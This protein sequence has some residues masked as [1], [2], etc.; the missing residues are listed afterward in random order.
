[1]LS[2]SL[3]WLSMV[4]LPQ[5][6]LAEPPQDPRDR[7]VGTWNTID[8]HVA[9]GSLYQPVHGVRKRESVIFFE[10]KGEGL[11]GHA[12]H[13]DHSAIIGQERWKDGR[14]EFR[15][16]RFEG[17]T[18]SFEFDIVEWRITAGPIAV[19]EK[20]IENAGTIRIEGK[21]KGDRLV[22]KWGMFL[23]DG[24]EVFRGEWEAMRSQARE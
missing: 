3:I 23:K 24:S 17:D 11:A 4:L 15:A 14:T 8:R 13:A 2:R 16:A 10:R 18:L 6:L 19:E 21:L 9:L 12:V 1:M 7:I 20:R 5:L 22:G